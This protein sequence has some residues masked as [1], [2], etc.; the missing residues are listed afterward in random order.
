MRRGDVVVV[1]AAGDYGK[2]RPAVVV[3]TDAFPETHP[4]VVICQMTSDVVNTQDF[5]VTV[6]GDSIVRL[7]RRCAIFLGSRH[8]CFVSGH[9]FSRAAQ[10]LRKNWAL[11][12]GALPNQ[13]LQ[14]TSRLIVSNPDARTKDLAH[15]VIK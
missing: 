5:R 3:Q 13:L 1:A 7:N 10:G 8:S 11:A 12:P 9:D 15:L 4:S 6:T 2:P 14:S